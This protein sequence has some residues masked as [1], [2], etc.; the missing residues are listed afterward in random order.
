MPASRKGPC[1]IKVEIVKP[2]TLHYLS[3]RTA[4]MALLFE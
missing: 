2:A 4:W 1:C 3:D